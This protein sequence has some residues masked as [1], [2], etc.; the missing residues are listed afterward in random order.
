MVALCKGQTITVD[1][2]GESSHDRLVGTCFLP[3][4][5]DLAAELVKQG[6]ALDWATFSGGKYRCFEPADARRRLMAVRHLNPSKNYAPRT[7]QA[8]QRS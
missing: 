4:G 6:L 2:D 5:R 7:A 8:N 3:D 1:L